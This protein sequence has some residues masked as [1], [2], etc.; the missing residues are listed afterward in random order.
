MDRHGWK[1]ET[2]ARQSGIAQT[3]IS[4]ILRADS[5]SAG[6]MVI[7]ALAHA[8]GV[9]AWMLL[10][11]FGPITDQEMHRIDRLLQVYARLPEIGKEQVDRVAEAES[12]YADMASANFT[13]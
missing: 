5:K 11:D 9:P 12:R 13:R 8:L 3:T 4:Y 7:D 2:L 6:I 1:Q 10:V